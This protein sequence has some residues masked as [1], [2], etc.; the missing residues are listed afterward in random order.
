MHF[1]PGWLPLLLLPLA[2]VALLQ[3]R[4]PA[5]I[6]GVGDVRREA[7]LFDHFALNAFFD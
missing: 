7:T 3:R 6:I 2:A 5:T 4:Q 1:Q